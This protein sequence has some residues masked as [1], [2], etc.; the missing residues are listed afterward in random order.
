VQEPK[1]LKYVCTGIFKLLYILVQKVGQ[2]SVRRKFVYD[3][4]PPYYPPGLF[5]LVA[6]AKLYVATGGN[7]PGERGVV[8]Y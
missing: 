1:L 2:M 5:P 7:K 3:S 4:A 8:H 6:S